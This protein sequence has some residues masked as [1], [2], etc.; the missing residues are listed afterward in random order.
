MSGCQEDTYTVTYIFPQAKPLL[1]CEFVPTGQYGI[2]KP[3]YFPF[4][5]SY[6]CGTS[7][8]TGVDPDMLKDS[9][10]HSGKLSVLTG[11]AQP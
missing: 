5:A 2:P 1:K 9:T 11:G 8:V 6:W 3:W 10:V 7:S 4:T